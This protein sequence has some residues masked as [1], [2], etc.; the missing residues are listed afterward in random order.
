MGGVVWAASESEQN[1]LRWRVQTTNTDRCANWAHPVFSE[2]QLRFWMWPAG[3]M[4]FP[5]SNMERKVYTACRWT[6]H[7]L[8]MPTDG[9]TLRL[10]PKLSKAP[11]QVQSRS[12]KE[13]KEKKKAVETCKS[14]KLT[15]QLN[16]YQESSCFSWNVQRALVDFL[17]RTLQTLQSTSASGNGREG[18]PWKQTKLLPRYQHLTVIA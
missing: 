7:Q 2:T 8:H 18:K 14:D 1:F 11:R 3:S 6:H 17:Q 13:K 15:S 16:K 9:A 4:K 12:I 5:Y 10:G